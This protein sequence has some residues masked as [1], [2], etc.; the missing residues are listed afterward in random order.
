VV[1]LC[2]VMQTASQLNRK[3]VRI[4]NDYRLRLLRIARE[5]RWTLK[6]AME[7]AVELLERETAKQGNAA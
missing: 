5:K 7:V 1:Y 6:A 4:S 3:A 2:E